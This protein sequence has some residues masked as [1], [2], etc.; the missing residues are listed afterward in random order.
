MNHLGLLLKPL[1]DQGGAPAG[2]ALRF[3]PGRAKKNP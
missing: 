1:P 3:V 2:V